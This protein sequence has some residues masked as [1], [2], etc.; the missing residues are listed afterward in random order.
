[1]VGVC[2]LCYCDPVIHRGDPCWCFCHDTPPPDS[3]RQGEQRQSTEE[4]AT[5]TQ[6]PG[7]ADD[8]AGRGPADPT[9]NATSR[10]TD[11]GR[12][13]DG[14]SKSGPRPSATPPNEKTPARG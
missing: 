10:G 8:V 2:P 12:D 6:H 5:D 14:Q 9:F 11:G 3:P 1:M 4:D 7:T 13:Q